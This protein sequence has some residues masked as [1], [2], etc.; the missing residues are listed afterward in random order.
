LSQRDLERDC[1]KTETEI[2]KDKHHEL[3]GDTKRWKT[4]LSRRASERQ[5]H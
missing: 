1:I 2:D 3:S 4:F 5:T